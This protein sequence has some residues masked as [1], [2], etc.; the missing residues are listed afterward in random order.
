MPGPIPIALILLLLGSIAAL[1]S[2]GLLA[3]WMT[4]LPRGDHAEAGLIYRLFQLLAFRL[5]GL[6]A[7]G[8]EHVPQQRDGVGPLI[9]VCNHTAG[10]DPVLVQ[11]LCRFEVRWM[12]AEDMRTPALEWLWEL[13]EVIFV[14]RQNGG[15]GV[16]TREALR[17]LKAGGVIG[18]FPEGNLERPPRT[19][20]PF[21]KG[22]GLLVKR[23]G[24]PVLPA[25]I[26]GT[27]QVDPAWA[28]IYRPSR[29]RVR[30]LAPVRYADSGLG[31]AEITEDLERRFLDAT[32]WPR[33]EAAAESAGTAS[34][35]E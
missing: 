34:R 32:G 31:A 14:D 2:F 19:L 28:S 27:P 7:R 24:A 22:V 23:S 4:F 20:L 33:G 1:M 6:R 10:I 13:G 9:V 12:M 17:H 35:A 5:H 26:D 11:A 29:S 15:G 8:L 21:M 25:V 18:I 3:R 16:S 30:F